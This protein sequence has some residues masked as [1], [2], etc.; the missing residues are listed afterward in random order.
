M[1]RL[2]DNGPLGMDTKNVPSYLPEQPHAPLKVILHF[3]FDILH[4]HNS[5]CWSKTE[6]ILQ[7]KVSDCISPE[8]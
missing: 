5:C 6:K 7:S 4:I 2:S 8:H 3:H 1:D